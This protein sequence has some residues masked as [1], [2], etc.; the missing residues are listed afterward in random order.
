MELDSRPAIIEEAIEW[1]NL[2]MGQGPVLIYASAASYEVKSI[3]EK[4]GSERAGS[5][6]ENAMGSIAK[7]LVDSG[8]RR[9]VVAGGET[10]GAV[11]GALGISSLQI[12]EQI[13]PGV[14]GT[15]TVEDPKIA[16]ALK[17]GNFGEV[18]FFQ[19]ALDTMP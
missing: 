17:S 7:A 6:I 10:A 2:R 16:L 19:K 18:D 15:I 14:P 11:V 4:I 13:D 9:L 1:A 8:V 12:G 5:L 3:Q